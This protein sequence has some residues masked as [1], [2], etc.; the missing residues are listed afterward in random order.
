MLAFLLSIQPLHGA[1]SLKL[2]TP[3]EDGME[4]IS[5]TRLRMHLEFLASKELGGRYTLSPNFQIA[6]RYLATRL[7]A[8]GFKGAAKDGSFFQ[9]FEVK[10]TRVE[11]ERSS[12]VL[13]AGTASKPF[14]YGSFFLAGN[15]GGT[16]EGPVV[17]VGYG[18]SSKGQKHDDY[19]GVDVRGK[20]V[21]IAPAN[22]TGV[23]A[24]RLGRLESKAGAASSHGA[25]AVVYLPRAYEIAAMNR[26]SYFDRSLESVDLAVDQQK[27]PSIR[28]TAEVAEEML[29]TAGISYHDLLQKQ[30]TGATLESK[31]LSAVLSINLKVTTKTDST[32]NV[33]GVLPGTDGTLR[34]EYV[35]FSAHYDHLREAN[36]KIYPGA[37]DDGSG[38]AGVLAI[39]E[40][41][42]MRRPR[43]SVLIIFHAGEEL[44]LLGSEFNTDYDP[45]VPLKDMVVNLNV[46]MIGRSKLPNDTKEANRQLTTADTIYVIGADRTSADLQQIS[47]RT[48]AEFEKLTFDYLLNDPAHPDQIFF[49]SDHWNYGKHGV[50]FI[51]YFDGVGEDYH[52]PTDTL[53]KI[54]YRKMTRVSRLIYATGWRVANLTQRLSTSTAAD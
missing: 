9:R 14:K 16:V 13:K 23:D 44:G 52:Q 27:I 11:P 3:P 50:P 12:I 19:T 21:L 54:D 40:A 5:P 38:T 6:A 47:V 15:E 39:A 35:A 1:T 4:T 8:Y 31:A 36:G 45:I 28:V 49:R 51:F 10:T 2:D 22:P 34:Q 41:M 20:I 24:R 42:G 32:Q 25:I 37:D 53:D 17:F 18:I 7:E 26:Q 48:N 43:R 46:D 30:R 33:V 29:K